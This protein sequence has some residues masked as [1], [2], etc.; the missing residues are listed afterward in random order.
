MS[1]AV[2]LSRADVLG[3]CAGAPGNGGIDVEAAAAEVAR[4]HTQAR[5]LVAGHLSVR[6]ALRFG[7]AL[8]VVS[9]L[10]LALTVNLLSAVLAAAAIGFYQSIGF[11]QDEVVS[12]GKR[13]IP[14]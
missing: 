1:E 9:V 6:S 13:L 12:Y 5:P 7:I 3:L 10:L 11:A 8:S 2:Y 14:D 4:T